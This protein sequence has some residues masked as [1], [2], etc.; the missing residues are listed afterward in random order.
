MV[1]VKL[2]SIDEIRQMMGTTKPIE[3]C[4]IAQFHLQRKQIAFTNEKPDQPDSEWLWFEYETEPRDCLP[5]FEQGPVY[6]V[7]IGDVEGSVYEATPIARLSTVKH[8]HFGAARFVRNGEERRF[9]LNIDDRAYYILKRDTIMKLGDFVIVHFPY[10]P[11]RV[12][13]A[14]TNGGRFFSY[15]K[16]WVF[17]AEKAKEVEEVLLG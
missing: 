12:E 2:F 9:F 15:L 16:V 10:D 11:K 6:G 13:W 5:L 1:T 4:M 8:V 14:K 17:P 7:L 3:G